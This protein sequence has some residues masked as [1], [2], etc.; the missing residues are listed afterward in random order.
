MLIAFGIVVVPTGLALDEYYDTTL[1]SSNLISHWTN[2]LQ[3]RRR[4]TFTEVRFAEET[5]RVAHELSR[6]LLV[7]C[8]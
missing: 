4:T 2:R 3:E 7:H 5:C 8:L 1:T 6:I